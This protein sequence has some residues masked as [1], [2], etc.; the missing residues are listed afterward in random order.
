MVRSIDVKEV[1]SDL[2]RDIWEHF[3][4]SNSGAR[5][6]IL[7][8]GF[9]TTDFASHVLLVACGPEESTIEEKGK[10]NSVRGVFTKALLHALESHGAQ[11]LTYRDL[12][13]RLPGLPM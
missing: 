9:A 5:A 4:P 12:L 7:A 11:G 3:R 10:N 6:G 2:D 8:S 1:P 13:Q